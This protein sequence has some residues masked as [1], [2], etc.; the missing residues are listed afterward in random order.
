MVKV[1]HRWAHLD[2]ATKGDY[3]TG[4]CTA[5]ANKGQLYIKENGL[6]PAN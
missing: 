5:A 1:A 3:H 4:L 2:D 6:S